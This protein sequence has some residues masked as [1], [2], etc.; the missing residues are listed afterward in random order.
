MKVEFIQLAE[1]AAWQPPFAL[2]SS[3]SREQR[4]RRSSGASVKNWSCGTNK[5][6]RDSGMALVVAYGAYIQGSVTDWRNETLAS[7]AVGKFMHTIAVVHFNPYPIDPTWEYNGALEASTV[8]QDRGPYVR[9]KP[10]Q[11]SV[12]WMFQRCTILQIRFRV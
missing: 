1:F 9:S 2:E 12:R 6:L 3:I 7:S 8:A 10:R 4:N 5:S 11:A